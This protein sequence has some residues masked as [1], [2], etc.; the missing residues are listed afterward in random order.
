MKKFLTLILVLAGFLS[1]CN[2]EVPQPD[3]SYDLLKEE[4]NVSYGNHPLQKMDVY[5]PEDY[6]AQTPVVFL[7][8]G[9]GFIAGS[10]E[11]FT[12]VALLFVN[13][14]Y[15]AVN[16]GHRLVNT[17][18][19]DQNPPVHKLSEVK[20]QDQVQDL[21]MAVQK[22]KQSASNWGSGTASLYMAG[23]S[24]GGTLALL[25]VQGNLNSGV[26]ASA[27]FA[28]LT[29]M[30]LTEE[31]Y[32]NPP[33]HVYWPALKELIYRMSGQEVVSSNALALMAI[34]PDWVV[35]NHKPGKPHITVMSKSNDEDLNFAPYY[36]TVKDAE[37]F[38][39]QLIRLQTKSQY[40]LMD[41]DHG[42]GNHPE[43]W[44]KAVTHVVNFFKTLP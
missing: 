33:D 2:E 7:I 35:N 9:G 31:L 17:D 23:H 4:L 21:A 20:V 16:L 39:Q 14:G 26:K 3:R 44:N 8:H 36:N 6:N 25:Y 42:F 10:K 18:G 32:N 40:I 27:N 34:S 5:F 28:G 43:D 41:T 37:D 24:A 30:T 13:K 22:Y 15:I 1:G 11:N 12:P 38:H 29:K 19:L